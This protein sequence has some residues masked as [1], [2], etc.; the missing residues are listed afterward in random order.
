MR[1]DKKKLSL[2]VMGFAEFSSIEI[3]T[4]IGFHCIKHN[5]LFFTF[6][7]CLMLN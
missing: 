3:L 2:N 4:V 1:C 6:L 5:K 7:S